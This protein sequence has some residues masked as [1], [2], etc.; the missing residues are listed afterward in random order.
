M[1]DKK[2]LILVVVI[3]VILLFTVG[4]TYAFLNYSQTGTSNSQLIVGDIYMHFKETNQLTIENA[5]PYSISYKHNS[6][7]TEEEVNLCVDYLTSYWGPEEDNTDPGE[8]YK[9]FCQ[10][11]GTRWGITFQEALDEDLINGED[12]I[13]FEEN[14]I[15]KSPFVDLPYFE[16]TID[17]KNTYEKEDIWY[18][19]VLSHGNSHATRK[20]RIKDNLLKFRLV[21]VIDGEEK[22]LFTNRSYKDLTNKRVWVDT[23]LKNTLNEVVHIYRLYMWIDDSV[24]IGNTVEAD[25][26][27]E[28]W[29]NEV[30]ASIKVNVTGD[31][32]EKTVETEA[33]CFETEIYTYYEHNSNISEEEVNLCVNYLTSNWGLEEDNTNPGETYES[34]CQGTGTISGITFQTWLDD[35]RF[36]VEDLIYFEENNIM[37]IGQEG[38][39]IKDYDASCGSDV[40]IPKTINGYPVTMITTQSGTDIPSQIANKISN[41]L[42]S[43]NLNYRN[44]EYNV[45]ELFQSDIGAFQN[46]GL[47]SVIIPDSVIYIGTKAFTENTLRSVV[48]P[49]SVK[50][51][52]AYA[53]TYNR[54]TSVIIPDNVTYLSCAAFDDFVEIT[55]R[56][57]LVCVNDVR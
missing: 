32:N 20:E 22:I 49:N 26:D 16:F 34:F 41:R 5:M 45:T 3:T 52:N 18:E 42:Y 44:K 53:F 39:A 46:K 11:T 57:D 31:F 19:I 21:E 2:V 12:L 56:D 9:S 25:Y 48:I 15:I 38:I 40:I 35:D 55:K 36:N 1:K 7:I 28:T 13:Y 14:N 23:I 4:V 37:I 43:N 10:G 33:S 54:I 27:I 29:N 50:S 30:Y 17:G 24:R 8:T 47:T 51:I 6:N